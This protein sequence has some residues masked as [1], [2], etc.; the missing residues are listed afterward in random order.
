[1]LLEQQR[2]TL[3]AFERFIALP[4]NRDRRFELIDGSIVEKPMP[5]QKHGRV[6]MNFGGELYIF[7]KANRL[8]FVESE[9]RYRPAGDTGNDRL[10]D[11]SVMLDPHTPAVGQGAVPRMPDIAA[12]VKSPDDSLLELREKIAFYLEHGTKLGLLFY[13]EKRLI[14]VYPQ[15][16]DAYTLTEDDTLEIEDLLPGF[17]VKVRDLFD[18]T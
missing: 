18:G 2:T 7:L 8:G 3:A 14:E 9:V 4:E 12:E 11:V 16:E 13:P 10:P 5:T 6:T 17:S 15:G 1:M